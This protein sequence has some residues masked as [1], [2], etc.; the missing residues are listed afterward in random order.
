[1]TK[2]VF[3]ILF[4]PCLFSIL[5][6]HRFASA[7]PAFP[8]AEGFG[9]D[10]IGGR[11]GLVFEVTNLNDS[12]PGSLR[13]AIEA[14]GPRIVVFR[15][16][17][18]ITLSS[19]LTI[20]NPY[21]T[22]AGQTAPGG[23]I[24]IKSGEISVETHDVVIRYITSRRGPGGANHAF[25][26]GDNGSSNVYNIIV[27]HCSFSWGTDETVSSWYAPHD[28]TISYS[29]ISEGLNCSTHEKGCHSKG[30]MMGGYKFK[31]SE[32]VGCGAKNHSFH[33]NLLAHHGSR[34]PLIKTS[35]LADVVNN[36]IYNIVGTMSQV[37]MQSTCGEIPVNYVGNYFKNGP[38]TISGKYEIAAIETGGNES[39]IYV[40]GNIG[41]HRTS[42]SQPETYLVKAD[43]LSYIVKTPN[44]VAMPVNA[45]SATTAYSELM[46]N[47]GVGNSKYVDCFGHW[48]NR[49]D[50]HDIRIIYDVQSGTA[51]NGASGN[52]IDNPSDV[53]GWLNIETGSACLDSD[54]DGMP[55]VWE[56]FYNFNPSSSSDSSQD[57]DNDGYTNIE[58]Y[59]NGTNP[60]YAG[61]PSKI[62]APPT[63]LRILE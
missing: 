26:I 8:G 62:P 32:P 50:D 46:D 31:E 29:I 43:S 48:I 39:A 44:S 59:L 11:G 58:E 55:D 54:H 21:I 28:Y 19:N 20:S 7:L 9:S 53:G 25:F 17:G 33:H 2:R 18:T 60:K 5:V 36:V 56:N 24:T 63:G 49:R 14:S 35:G 34:G 30:A 22:V 16:G 51:F 27:D 47:G 3:L 12:G 10:T 40:Q 57:L 45:T 1:M 37:D 13:A 23:G 15:T 42:D 38:N 61:Y 6:G 4:I 41:P 52:I